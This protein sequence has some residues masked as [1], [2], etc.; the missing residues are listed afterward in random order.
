MKYIIIGLGNYGRVLAIELSLL[1]HEVIGADSN[2]ERVE[3]VKDK[4]ATAFIMDST[5]ETAISVLPLHD[6]D[7]VIVTIGED[8]GASIRTVAI[9]K[10]KNVAHIYARSTDPIHRAILDAFGLEKILTPEE[11]AARSLVQLLNFGTQ[12][13]SFQVDKEHYVI[14]IRVTDKI[15]GKYINDL[16]LETEF[17]LRLITLTRKGA[18]VNSIGVSTTEDEVVPKLH[19]NDRLQPGDVLVCYGRYR[20]FQAFLK[21]I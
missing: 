7:V 21:R 19:Q 12:I 1:G 5:D 6:V 10:Q 14:K 11:D 9:L 16:N 8:L 2:S 3:S 15:T 4:I 20:N 17:N 13:E 18:S